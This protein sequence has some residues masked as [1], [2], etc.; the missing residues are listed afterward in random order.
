VWVKFERLVLESTTHQTVLDL[1][2]GLTVVCEVGA[3]EREVLVGEFVGSLG[4]ARPGVHLEVCTDNDRHLAVFRPM[5]AAHRVVD[6][7][8]QAD[9]TQEFVGPGGGIDLLATAG[10]TPRAAT[11][12]MRLTSQ[13]LT[14]ATEGD[15]IAAALAVVDQRELWMSAELLVEARAHLDAESARAGTSA[16]D[17][18]IVARIEQRHSEFERSLEQSEGVRK[19]SF[20]LAGLAALAAVPAAQQY[21]NGS[22]AGLAAVA[23]VA[24][25]VSVLSST[26]SSVSGL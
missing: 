5:G 25:M 15:E 13:A 2:P 6:V 22:V 9:V 8:G 19:V 10:L 1:H 21:G 17:A 16:T 18:E 26:R 7:D 24:V 12:L 14:E 4:S 20:V 11:R 3:L 23:A